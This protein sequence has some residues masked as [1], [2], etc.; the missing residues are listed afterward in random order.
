LLLLL[1]PIYN[2]KLTTKAEQRTE[3]E[4]IQVKAE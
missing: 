1:P 2:T 4:D 3:V